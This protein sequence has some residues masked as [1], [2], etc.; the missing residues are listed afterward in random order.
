LVVVLDDDWMRL[1]GHGGQNGDVFIAGG[2]SVV[3]ESNSCCCCCRVFW[4][5]SSFSSSSNPR[6]SGLT[7]FIVVED[8]CRLHKDASGS[9]GGG[10]NAVVEN[11]GD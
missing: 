4:S 11:V 7:V 6:C 9:V 2:S 10:D 8:V 3:V 1:N 5:F